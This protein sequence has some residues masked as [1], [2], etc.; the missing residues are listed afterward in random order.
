MGGGRDRGGDR[1]DVVCDAEG[2]F[3]EITVC[4]GGVSLSLSL[5]LPQSQS[6][7]QSQPLSLSLSLPLSLT[8]TMCFYTPNQ[9]L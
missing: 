6:Q 1:G 7:S 8:L 3:V 2:R 4:G 9:R 5:S